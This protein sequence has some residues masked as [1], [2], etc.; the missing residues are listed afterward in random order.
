M[1]GQ[2]AHAPAGALGIRRVLPLSAGMFVLG[3]DA[4]VLSGVL[5]N[6]SDDLHVTVGAAGQMVTA[7]TLSY[8]LL[9]PVLA[10]VSGTWSRRRVLLGALALF[11]AANVVSA[12]APDL[13]VLIG[14][15]GR[16]GRR[17]RPV[18]AHSRRYCRR[19]GGPGTAQ[20]GAAPPAA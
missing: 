18:R 5:G 17:G 3:L 2:A 10:T 6:I 12:L 9:S 1:T 15:R 8:A 11:T 7:F 16:R 20:A 14:A 4:Y 19:A 13:A